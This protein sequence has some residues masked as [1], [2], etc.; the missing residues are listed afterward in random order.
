M[1]DAT[2]AVQYFLNGFN[3]A[4]AVLTSCSDRTQIHE[5]DLLKI[6]C[7][8]GAGM[9][10]L[11]GTCGAVTGAAMAIGL[12]YGNFQNDDSEA[13]ENTY[14]LIR[15]FDAEFRKINKSTNC[16]ELL[17]CSLSTPEGRKYFKENNLMEKICVKCV[18]D[19]VNILKRM[20]S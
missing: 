17:G 15:E 13:K 9:G 16:M 19:A 10:R 18:E 12:K 6:S 1:V 5:N 7:G 20:L 11:Q 8:F 4:Q 3:C 14:R 2:K